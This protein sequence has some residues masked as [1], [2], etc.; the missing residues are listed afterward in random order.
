MELVSSST[1]AAGVCPAFAGSGV[2][3]MLYP[4]PARD[5]GMTGFFAQRRCYG[6]TYCPQQVAL[7]EVA[8][9]PGKQASGVSVST[10]DR[11]LNARNPVRRASAERVLE[12]AEQIGFYASTVIKQR[13]G[14]DRPVF[15]LCST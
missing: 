10:V 14:T 8:P 3:N 11:V 6:Q 5:L 15:T 2:S 4:L 1:T 7:A 13:P 12:A 9:R